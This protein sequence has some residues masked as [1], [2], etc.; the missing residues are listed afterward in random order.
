MPQ[1]DRGHHGGLG[2]NRSGRRSAS[3]RL[4]NAIERLIHVQQAPAA[5]SLTGPL[6]QLFSPRYTFHQLPPSV[7]HHQC[8]NQS[9]Y[10][11]S[12]PPQQQGQWLWNQSALPGQWVWQAASLPPP[13]PNPQVQQEYHQ[14]LPGGQQPPQQGQQPLHS[15]YPQPGYPPPQPA[16]PLQQQLQQHP[17]PVAHPRPQQQPVQQPAQQPSEKEGYYVNPQY[18]DVPLGNIATVEGYGGSRNTA[19]RGTCRATAG[20]PTSGRLRRHVQIASTQG[21]DQEAEGQTFTG[22]SAADAVAEQNHSLKFEDILRRICEDQCYR[23]D[24]TPEANVRWY[25]RKFKKDARWL[26]KP[27]TLVNTERTSTPPA[28][29]PLEGLQNPRASQEQESRSQRCQDHGLHHT[30]T[31]AQGAEASKPPRT[32]ADQYERAKR[33]RAEEADAPA[34]K[35]KIEAQSMEIQQRDVKAEEETATEQVKVNAE[36]AFLYVTDYQMKQLLRWI[37]F[38]E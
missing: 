34:K 20:N 13:P 21:E 7:Q 22:S 8:Q 38:H 19:P 30:G 15:S 27:A 4:A 36:N 2:R 16:Q 23:H 17:P 28:P 26:R 1:G 37:D 35:I 5:T 33:W 3:M 9:G 6:N 11:T 18:R 31:Q 14:I 25:R 29:Q 32:K 10:A 24:L 12:P